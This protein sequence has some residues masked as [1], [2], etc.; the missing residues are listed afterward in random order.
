MG[1]KSL[2]QIRPSGFA[3]DWQ[4]SPSVKFD[5]HTHPHTHTHIEHK[6]ELYTI[7]NCRTHLHIALL[8]L[9]TYVVGG[10]DKIVCLAA[11]S[12]FRFS[13]LCV[14]IYTHTPL[15]L[16]E[17]CPSARAPINRTPQPT[18][19]MLGYEVYIFIY[20]Y[21]HNRNLTFSRYFSNGENRGKNESYIYSSR[22]PSSE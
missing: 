21:S 15:L 1:I 18:I 9:D 7:E 8:L 14:Y 10:L 2:S 5:Q 19:L 16:L 6:K 22:D 12:M 13:S 3:M 11:T 17:G 4:T 20:I